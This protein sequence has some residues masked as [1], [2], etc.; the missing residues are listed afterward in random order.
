MQ[1]ADVF[2]SINATEAMIVEASVE[3]SEVHVHPTGNPCVYM[4]LT[5][6]RA[7]ALIRRLE[8][9]IAKLAIA[10]AEAP[11]APEKPVLSLVP[12]E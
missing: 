11:S 2:V 5:P 4:A 6:E 1:T 3:T 8:L 10:E 12:K 9:S 7:G